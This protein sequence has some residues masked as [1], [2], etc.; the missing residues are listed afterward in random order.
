M[1]QPAPAG[2][3]APRVDAAL[4]VI[5]RTQNRS[6]PPGTE[7]WLRVMSLGLAQPEALIGAA[8]RPADLAYIRV[9]RDELRIGS[10]TTRAHILN[11]PVVSEYCAPLAEAIRAD[12]GHA[13]GRPT[14]IGASLCGGRPPDDVTTALAAV[15]ASVV[16]RSP[17]GDRIVP[18][19][20]L[21]GP[22]NALARPGE[23]LAEVR[24]PRAPG[25]HG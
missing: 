13:P 18:V 5:S 14:T 2:F 25:G 6:V 4:G 12:P 22:G 7:S 20:R 9:V 24:I 17:H 23:L 10:L 1:T 11:S 15:R 3:T 16:I 19:A 8:E 21:L